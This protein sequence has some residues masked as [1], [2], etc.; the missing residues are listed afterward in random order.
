MIE[1]DAQITSLRDIVPIG[2]SWSSSSVM[3]PLALGPD[4][5]ESPAIVVDLR[6][7]YVTT[8]HQR[9]EVFDILLKIAN[10]VQEL[11]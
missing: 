8:F 1:T 4:F 6:L 10:S 11:V 2:A 7:S 9:F 3:S 5:V